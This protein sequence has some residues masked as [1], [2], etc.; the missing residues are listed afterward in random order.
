MSVLDPEY[1]PPWLGTTRV[2]LGDPRDPVLPPPIQPPNLPNSST[3]PSASEII[4]TC[5]T[6]FS[7]SPGAQLEPAEEPLIQV[8]P[9]V[10][11]SPSDPEYIRSQSIHSAGSNGG[12][13]RMHP[14]RGRERDIHSSIHPFTFQHVAFDAVG[15]VESLPDKEDASL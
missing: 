8:A 2:D 11:T 1:V 10:W 15:S 5:S 7:T 6:S 4:S 14:R 13:W 12:A 9:G 3:E